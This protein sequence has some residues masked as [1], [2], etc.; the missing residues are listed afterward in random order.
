MNRWASTAQTRAGPMNASS[1]NPSIVAPPGTKWK[2]ASRCVPECTLIVTADALVASPRE[3]RR[4]SISSSGGA[5]TQRTVSP[6]R[7]SEISW[8]F[9][10]TAERYAG[11]ARVSRGRMLRCRMH[12]SATGQNA[13]PRLQF[14]DG[15]QH[16]GQRHQRLA[17]ARANAGDVLLGFLRDF[18]ARDAGDELFAGGRHEER[19]VDLQ[20]ERVDAARPRLTEGGHDV[21]AG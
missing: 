19:R 4:R 18:S 15:R 16:R 2:G 7:L 1:G 5:A 11:P 9:P 10:G 12:V 3:M 6:E 14:A 21:A 8:I 17:E 13:T 20:L